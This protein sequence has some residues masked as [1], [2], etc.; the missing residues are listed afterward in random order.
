MKVGAW[1]ERAVLAPTSWEA[2]GWSERGQT[3]RFQ[4]VSEALELIAGDSV[5]DFGCGTGRF[6]EF[7]PPLIEYTGYDTS[8]GMLAR[9]RREHPEARFLSR[10]GS[11]RYDHIV[12]VGTFNLMTEQAMLA[13]VYGLL[14]RARESVV[15]SLYCG[16]DGRCTRFSEPE[17]AGIIRGYLDNDF[18]AVFR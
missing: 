18:L 4:A 2:A 13:I 15:V 9:A 16:K 7:L 14:E 3:K 10:L 1:D 17:G 11:E 5:L 12:C 6:L 8:S